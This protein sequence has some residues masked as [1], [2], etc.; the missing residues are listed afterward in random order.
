MNRKVFFAT[1]AAA[2]AAGSF[3]MAGELEQACVAA[4]EAEG[5]DTSGCACLEA[6]VV[7]NDLVDEFLALGEIADVDER[8]EAASPAAKAAMDMCTR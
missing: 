6:E 4:L 1:V 5:R 7:A 2:C 8:Y 3:A